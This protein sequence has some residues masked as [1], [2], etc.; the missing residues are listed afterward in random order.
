MLKMRSIVLKN[1][2]RSI[3]EWRITNLSSERE[4]NVFTFE[5]ACGQKL[6]LKYVNNIPGVRVT[7]YRFIE[8]S[9]SLILRDGTVFNFKEYG[10]GLYYYDMTITYE[11]NSPKKTQQLPPT[12]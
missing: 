7:M 10:S 12:P 9:M 8:K 1:R 11:Q 6:S 3:D 5:Y 4:L 2:T